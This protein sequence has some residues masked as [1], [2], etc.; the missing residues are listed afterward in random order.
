MD[1]YERTSEDG[2]AGG[3]ASGEDDRLRRYREALQ[4][5]AETEGRADRAERIQRIFSD[6][7]EWEPSMTRRG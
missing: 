4:V 3:E 7:P 5:L 1:R 2:G 6:E